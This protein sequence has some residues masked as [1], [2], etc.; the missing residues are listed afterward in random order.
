MCKEKVWSFLSYIQKLFLH[1]VFGDGEHM[2]L[3]DS[4]TVAFTD[5]ACYCHCFVVGASV[6]V[7]G[8]MYSDVT[9]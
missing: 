8:A 3:I 1:L 2:L 7:K 5:A 6:C 4:F 9:F